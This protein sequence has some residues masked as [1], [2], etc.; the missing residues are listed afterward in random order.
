MRG[1]STS[2]RIARVAAG[3]L[4]AHSAD[5]APEAKEAA[6]VSLRDE[7]RIHAAASGEVGVPG[8]VKVT[9]FARGALFHKVGAK[10]KVRFER[11]IQVAK[12]GD[13]FEAVAARRAIAR[14]LV[15]LVEAGED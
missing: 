5:Q 13:N 9:S 6:T 11:A 14:W 1:R 10:F 12:V 7:P 3:M 15:P 2:G 4:L 8:G